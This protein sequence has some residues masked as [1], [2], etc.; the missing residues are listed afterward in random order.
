MPLSDVQFSRCSEM[1]VVKILTLLSHGLLECMLPF[2][3]D[4]RRDIETHLKEFFRLSLAIQVKAAHVLYRHGQALRLQK[5]FTVKVDRLFSDPFFFYFFGYLDLKT[6]AYRSPVFLVPSDVVHREA[7]HTRQGNLIH[8]NFVASMDPGS[9]DRFQ[10]YGGEPAE[11]VARL[12]KFLREQ[13]GTRRA[14]QAARLA[15]V[16]RE[17]GSILVGCAA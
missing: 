8:Y 16:L 6:M 7:V 1:E 12:V 9:H 2:S 11:I 5:R 13:A 14:G 3:D 17:P 4:E 15:A 10:D